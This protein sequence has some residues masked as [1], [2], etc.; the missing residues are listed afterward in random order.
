MTHFQ[1]PELKRMF[2]SLTCITR[3]FAD[4]GAPRLDKDCQE[5]KRTMAKKMSMIT[6]LAALAMI[7]G[8]GP[9]FAQYGGSSGSAREPQGRQPSAATQ[10]PSQT[11]RKSPADDNFAKKAAEG[12]M[13]EVKFGQLAEEKGA[14]PAVRN[15]GRRMVQ[16]HSKANNEL[17]NVTSKGSIP[18][19]N[20][21]DKSDQATYERLSKL[22]GDAFDRAYARDMVRDHSKDVSEFQ[23]EA[24]DGQNEAI[25]NFAAQTLP[26]LQSHL[27]QARQMEQAVN[28]ASNSASSENNTPANSGNSYPNNARTT[29]PTTR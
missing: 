9:A 12:G 2:K 5:V 13:A 29:P 24:K 27:D 17:K 1:T 20:Q 19:P 18:L 3:L 21:L 14:S 8:A 28:R 11:N 23:K 6:G 16:D 10:E 26:T 15:F 22:S 25:K 7:F 4:R